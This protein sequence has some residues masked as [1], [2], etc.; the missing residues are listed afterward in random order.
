MENA[1]ICTAAT[2]AAITLV[3]LK[4]K[5]VGWKKRT[6]SKWKNRRRKKRNGRK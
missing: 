2:A 4:G 3:Q 6:R 1:E 5:K